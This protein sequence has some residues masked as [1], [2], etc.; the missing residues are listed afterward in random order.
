MK[1]IEAINKNQVVLF[2]FKG[3]TNEAMLELCKEF[4]NNGIEMI[5]FSNPAEFMLQKLKYNNIDSSNIFFIDCISKK[6]QK[7]KNII[8]IPGPEALTELSLAISQLLKSKATDI[9]ILDSISTMLIDNKDII[10][11]RFLHDLVGKVRNTQK[12]LVLTILAKDSKGTLASVPLFCDAVVE[13]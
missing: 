3:N 10:L 1:A 2:V 11:V 7:S 5:L 9:V 4:S 12:K 6:N 13:A 8:Y